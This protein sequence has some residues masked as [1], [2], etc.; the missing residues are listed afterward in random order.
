MNITINS[1]YDLIIVVFLVS[2]LILYFSFKDTIYLKG[3]TLIIFLRILILT[4]LIVLLINPTFEY[5][6]ERNFNM[7]WHVYVDKSLSIKNHKQP[8]SISYKNGIQNFLTKVQKKGVNVETF[9]FGS[10]LDTIENISDLSLDGN[11]TNLGLV[12]DHIDYNYQNNLAGMIIFTDGQVNQGP[13]IQQYYNKSNT[14]PIHIIGIGDTTPMQDVSIKSV[15]IPPLCV[16]GENINIDVKI[17]SLGSVKEKINVTL[18]DEGG[19]LI[20]SKIIKITGG[21]TVED[22]RFQITPNKIGE[23]KFL[24][25]CSA[26]SQ[27]INI[28]NNQQKITLHVMKDQYNIALVTG[29]PSYNTGLLKNY[30]IRK[31]NNLVDHYIINNENF[32]QKIKIFLEK[33]YEIVIFDNNPV[34]SSAKKWESIARVFA[35]KLLSHNSSFF[36]VPGSEIDVN[37]LNRYLKIIDLEAKPNQ[38]DLKNNKKWKFISAWHK[39]NS[40]YNQEYPISNSDL[41]PPQNPAFQMLNINEDENI[42]AYA[43]YIGSEQENP[44]LILGEKHLIRYAV[45]NSIDLFSLKYMPLNSDTDFLFENSIKKI[46]NWLLKKSNNNEFIF[47][48]DKNS[49]QHGESVSLIGIASDMNNKHKMKDGIVELYHNNQYVGS[50]PLFFNLNE[51]VYKANFWAPKPGEIDYK[52]KMNINL[53]SHE[54]S[55]GSFKV[56]E[57]HIELNSIFLNEAK[58]INLSKPSTSG[59]FRYWSN[60]D[61][62][63]NVI[64]NMKKVESYIAVLPLRYNYIYICFIIILLYIEWSYRKKIRLN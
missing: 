36:I 2:T 46:T 9:S 21:Q 13:P 30:F 17:S 10:V 50:K 14:I 12:F 53:E 39:L 42:N 6:G 25:K 44:L 11:S 3:I 16:K 19:K 52:V 26:L 51:N 58:L 60:S 55:S 24:V 63:I 7:P 27:E 18:F 61:D 35:K 5:R 56:Q 45:W 38:D 1:S 4:L 31:G 37:S 47:R 33:K 41:I 49:Y 62:L 32:N 28:Q 43:K 40:V 64:D 22:V 8:S 15:D 20:G 48:T 59:S 57:S 23:N 54:V 34:S 29:A